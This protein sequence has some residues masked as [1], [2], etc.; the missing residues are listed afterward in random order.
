[1]NIHAA[2]G[3]RIVVTTRRFFLGMPGAASSWNIYIVPP[4]K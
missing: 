1:M 3:E 4:A 2:N